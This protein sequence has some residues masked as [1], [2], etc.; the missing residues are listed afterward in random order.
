MSEVDLSE[1]LH[2]L[3]R[4]DTTPPTTYAVSASPDLPL[5]PAHYE[6]LVRLFRNL[7]RNAI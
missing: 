1:L 5:V 6:E 2:A 4:S 3:L 7:I